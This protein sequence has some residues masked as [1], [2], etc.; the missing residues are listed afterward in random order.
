MAGRGAVL[1]D[2][3]GTLT[4]RRASLERFAPIFAADF[5]DALAAIEVDEL[6]RRLIACDRGGYNPRRA[7][8]L[9]EALPWR[10]PPA[11]SELTAY[12]QR[13]FPDAVLPQP[14]LHAVLETLRTAGFRLGVVTNGE[15][16]PQT[17]KLERLGVTE[18]VDDVVISAAV[19]CKKPDPRIFEIALRGVDVAPADCWFVGDH[20]ANDVVGSR[21]FGMRAVWITD[22]EAGFPWPEGEPEAP[23]RITALT[24]LLAIVGA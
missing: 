22:P 6:A 24:Q 21:R 3:D 9:V 1:F 16:V 7:E 18:R 5:G 19:E 10:E 14:G 23:H 17:R 4:P 13:R 8:D 12:W 11:P 20:P 15:V 2:L